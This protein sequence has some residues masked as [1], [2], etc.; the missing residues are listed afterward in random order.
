MTPRP[1]ADLIAHA[2][3][4]LGTQTRLQGW[5]R[6]RRDSKAGLSFIQLS[7]GSCFASMQVVAPSDLSN[8]ESDIL[9]LTAGCSIVVEGEVV[10]S[11]GKGQAI[12]VKASR[13]D[14]IGL[15]DD[16]GNLYNPLRAARP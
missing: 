6:T 11:R 13:I 8:Y 12:E 1:I 3:D 15:V 2:S 9:H 10:E 16:P 14:V 5:V 4:A 7:D